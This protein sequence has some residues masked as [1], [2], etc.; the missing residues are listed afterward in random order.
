MTEPITVIT[1]DHKMI[2]GELFSMMKIH[3]QLHVRMHLNTKKYED[4]EIIP[5]NDILGPEHQITYI[6]RN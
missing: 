5:I 6:S 1:G 3:D 4:G 2:D